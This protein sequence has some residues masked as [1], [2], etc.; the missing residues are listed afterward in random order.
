MLFYMKSHVPA[1]TCL[2]KVNLP[3][4][5]S[6]VGLSKDDLKAPGKSAQAIARYKEFVRI[7]NTYPNVFIEGFGVWM[8]K[9]P[10]AYGWDISEYESGIELELR[11]A[12][13]KLQKNAKRP[14]TISLRRGNAN[15]L[16]KSADKHKKLH[17]KISNVV[18]RKR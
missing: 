9:K 2:L 17:N 10:H 6:I 8:D 14:I 3:G 13:Y 16:E 15:V 5:L 12:A 7:I 11:R 18:Y 1:K 4:M